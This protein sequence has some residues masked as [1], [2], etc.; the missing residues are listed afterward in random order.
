MTMGKILI[1]I[2]GFLV[3]IGAMFIFYKSQPTVKE[4]KTEIVHLEAANDSIKKQNKELHFENQ[5]L[6]IKLF[7]SDNALQVL[8]EKDAELL[9]QIQNLT[10]QMDNIKVKYE[11][12]ANFTRNYTSDSISNYF[13]NLK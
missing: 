4:M 11:K 7:E 9:L 10:K 3:P 1:K 12:A 13:S 8:K 6:T 2:L 5:T